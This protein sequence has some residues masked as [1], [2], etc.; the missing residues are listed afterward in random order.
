MTKKLNP[1]QSAFV[2]EFLIDL[3]ATQAA[4]R[5]GY[6]KKTAGAIGHELLKKPEIMEAIQKGQQR[7]A[8][9]CDVTV[10]SLTAEYE[11][12]RALASVSGQ[13]ATMVSA[14]T[15]KAK[16]HGLVTDRAEVTG[17]DGTPLVLWG[18]NAKD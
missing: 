14:T 6:S 12:A 4:I 10:D 17:K 16:L 3:N 13:T 18:G 8:A 11:E 9:R 2:R 5:A 1:K 7:H 15:G